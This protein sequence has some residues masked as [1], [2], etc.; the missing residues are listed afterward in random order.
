M[1]TTP[2]FLFSAARLAASAALACGL[3]LGLAAPLASPAAAQQVDWVNPDVIELRAQV[4]R[5]QREVDRLRAGGGGGGLAGDSSGGGAVLTGDSYVRLDRLESDLRRLTGDVEQ[6]QYKVRRALTMRDQ[7]IYDLQ[8]RIQVLEQKSGGPEPTPPEPFED[9]FAG[10]PVGAGAF[11]PAAAGGALAAGVGVPAGGV[12][13]ADALA[14]DGAPPGILGEVPAGANVGAVADKP[15]FESGGRP[16]QPN[17]VAA[18]SN[19]NLS[20]D[21][22]GALDSLRAGAFDDAETQ[23]RGFISSNPSDPRVGEATYWIGET[24]YVRGLY[25]DAA[26][27]FLESFRTYP[28]SPK[29]PDSLLK[30]GM[31]LSQLNQHSEAC[32]TFGEVAA[33]YPDAPANVLRRADVEARRAGCN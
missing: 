22:D 4:E 24:Q 2:T 19:A 31:T 20:G 13:A 14:G 29:A 6:M 7:R 11:A 21:Y 3:A 26:K 8:Y 27:T 10:D 16:A 30:L 18:A 1:T 9:V 28:N 25:D 15:R 5:L 12:P 33:R 17:Q 32:M 23:F